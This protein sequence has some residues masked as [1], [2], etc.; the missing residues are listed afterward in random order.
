MPKPKPPQ[1]SSLL[2]K[3]VTLSSAMR[4][5]KLARDTETLRREYA[6]ARK[7]IQLF[8]VR[9]GYGQ[10]SGPGALQLNT[11]TAL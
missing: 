1:V 2:G 11:S 4:P 5:K 9:N 3:T 7:V 8:R 6:E 10:R